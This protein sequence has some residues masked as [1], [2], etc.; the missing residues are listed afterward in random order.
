MLLAKIL[1]W[2]LASSSENVVLSLMRNASDEIR[3]KH[4]MDFVIEVTPRHLRLY[5]L[6][7]SRDS[8]VLQLVISVKYTMLICSIFRSFIY[9]LSN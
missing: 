4:S 6:E 5:Y 8:I 2:S 3:Y 7:C 9:L 1:L